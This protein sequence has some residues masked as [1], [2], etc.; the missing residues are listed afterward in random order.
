MLDGPKRQCTK[1]ATRCSNKL[2][3]S[4]PKKPLTW[5]Y[6]MPLEPAMARN[7]FSRQ[8]WIV[9]A[10]TRE[11]GPRSVR[12]AGKDRNRKRSELQE[13]RSFCPGFLA[14]GLRRHDIDF[15]PAASSPI[16]V[17]LNA[18]AVLTFIQTFQDSP[19]EIGWS[20]ALSVS[21]GQGESVLLQGG[22]HDCI[23]SKKSREVMIEQQSRRRKA[24]SE[25]CTDRWN[26]R[27]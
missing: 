27:G 4:P 10:A 26:S 25:T 19:F 3:P 9:A 1:R 18:R 15:I 20:W 5:P 8:D 14:P 7:L 13:R 21:I 6:A 12:F 16:W 2:V 22:Y 23:P 24:V 11:Q 17:A